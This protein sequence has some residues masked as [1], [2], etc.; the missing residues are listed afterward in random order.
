MNGRIL[1]QYFVEF[2]TREFLKAVADPLVKPL[3]EDAVADIRRNLQRNDQFDLLEW[4][5]EESDDTSRADIEEQA[6]SLRET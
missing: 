5:A 6:E 3:I 4:L 2:D 1:R